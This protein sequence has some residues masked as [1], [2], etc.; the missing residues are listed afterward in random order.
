MKQSYEDLLLLRTIVKDMK[1][2]FI[3]SFILLI[4]TVKAQDLS[5]DLEQ[6]FQD[7]ELMGLSVWVQTQSNEESFHFG[8]RDFDRNLS[9]NE[10][11]HFRIASISKSVTALGLMKLYHDGL[12][13]WDDDVSDA[14]GYTLRNPQFPNTPIT[15][16]MLVSHQSS[17]QDGSGYNNFLTATYS[18]NPIPNISELL[19]PN[20]N[21]YTPNMWRVETPGTYFAYS[22]INFG[23]LGTLIEKLSGERF[24]IYMRTEI[25]EPLAVT[26]SYNIQDLPDINDVAVLYRY[27]GGWNVQFDNYLGVLPPPPDLS[28]YVPGTNGIYFGPQG[29]LR[30]TASDVGKILAFIWND[31]A[32]SNLNIDST[33]LQDMKAIAWDYNGSNGDNY[34]GLFNRWGLG[35]HHAN[36]RAGDQICGLTSF[37]T[38]LGHPGEAYG[39]ISDGYFSVSDGVGFTLLINGSKNGYT[40]GSTSSYYTVEEELFSALCTYFSNLGNEDTTQYTF[41]IYPN[42]TQGFLTIKF[43]QTHTNVKFQLSTVTGKQILSDALNTPTSNH[44]MNLN[45]LDSGLYFLEIAT[46]NQTYIKKIII[47]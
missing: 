9:V 4:Y 41:E 1:K 7:F 47:Q 14:L 40:I 39:L 16:R 43:A 27:Q 5:Q 37:D 31:G 3:L 38:F 33:I 36:T 13:E 12:F 19:L 22:N 10:D 6:I 34:G 46:Q 8:L 21:Y 32:N 24:D 2:I 29:S 15:Y 42:P 30:A 45:G 20:G 26:S 11:T 25:F 28:G 18:S 17:L 44:T 23:L 35:L